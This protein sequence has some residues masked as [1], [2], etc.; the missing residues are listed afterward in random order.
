LIK[1]RTSSHEYN[2][3]IPCHRYE[4]PDMKRFII[5]II[6]PLGLASLLSGCASPNGQPDNTANG[7]LIGGASGAAIGAI[8]DRRDPG[9]GALIGGAAGAITGGLIGHSV[10]EQ[11]QAQAAAAPPPG[12]YAPPPSGAP[13]SVADIKGMARSGLNDDVIIGEISSTH[14]VYHLDANS[15]IDLHNSGV[16][17][18]VI[19]YMVNTADIVAAQPPPAPQLETVTVAPGPDYVWN[20]GE[21]VWNGGVWVWIG[22]RWV[23]PPYPHAL[24]IGGRW[25][26]GP[27]GWHRARGHWR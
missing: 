1:L 24:W 12:Y 20:G 9:V 2:K 19:A 26:R 23:L 5:S 16:S 21:W 11:N 14:A 13:P 18:K 15:I 25:D 22:G 8:A 7:A 27:D 4:R 17:E 3:P 6:T 10:D